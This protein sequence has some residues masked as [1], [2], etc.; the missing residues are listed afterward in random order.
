MVAT[1]HAAFTTAQKR[2][3]VADFTRIPNGTGGLEDR[4]PV[5]WTKGVETGRLTPDKAID[6]L[7]DEMQS[8]LKG[9]VKI[10]EK[11]N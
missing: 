6:F 1:D 11:L 5:L 3:G 8:E 10:V 9:S 7:E 2:M 4:M